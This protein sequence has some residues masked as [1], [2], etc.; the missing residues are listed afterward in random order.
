MPTLHILPHRGITRSA[1]QGLGPCTFCGP[2]R[3]TAPLGSGFFAA[4]LR[5]FL[6]RLDGAVT[7][8]WSKK[9]S[10]IATMNQPFLRPWHC[11]ADERYSEGAQGIGSTRTKMAT[12]GCTCDS[13]Q[14]ERSPRGR[15]G[16][17]SLRNRLS[18]CSSLTKLTFLLE[19]GKML[20]PRHLTRGPRYEEC[21]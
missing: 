8:F 4:R 6:S 10:S 9:A 17:N 7:P 21:L 14:D 3:Q 16:L 5:A 11:E 13:Y 18:T 2:Y 15:R 20:H 12:R 19:C 1:G